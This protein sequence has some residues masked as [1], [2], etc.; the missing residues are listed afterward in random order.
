[1]RLRRAARLKKKA[2][3]PLR[4]KALAQA[5]KHLGEKESPAGSNICPVTRWWG[6]IGAWCCMGV[7]KCYID[8]GSKSFSK[9]GWKYTSCGVIAAAAELGRDGLSVTRDPKPGDLVLMKWPGL[10]SY[11][12]DHIEMVETARPLRTI[13][14]N[15]GPDNG[16]QSNG[17]M[18][19][20][21]N[22]EDERKSGIIRMYLHVSK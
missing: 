14:F 7:S 21:K 5:K 16:S 13:G 22:R 10:T 3:T 1:M 11:R 15:T 20:R 18:C 8:A 17:G 9:K 2:E 12:F 19:T 6:L 4:L